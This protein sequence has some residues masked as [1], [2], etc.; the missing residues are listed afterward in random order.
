MGLYL[1]QR[2]NRSPVIDTGLACDSQFSGFIATTNGVLYGCMM[3]DVTA[4][5]F[6]YIPHSNRVF[7]VSFGICEIY[8]EGP[9]IKTTQ[10]SVSEAEKGEVQLTHPYFILTV[11]LITSLMYYFNKFSTAFT[12]NIQTMIPSV[13]ATQLNG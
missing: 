8:D 7:I 5:C 2:V 11:R 3:C 10:T 13:F 9:M 12:T 4:S 6:Y 1:V